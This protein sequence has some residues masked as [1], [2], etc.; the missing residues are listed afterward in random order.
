MGIISTV[1]ESLTSD[2]E[3]R[4]YRY[5]CN[6]CSSTFLSNEPTVQSVDCPNCDANNVR[7]YH[8]GGGR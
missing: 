7:E 2:T 5:R 3:E 8:G 4:Q 1:R 6:V